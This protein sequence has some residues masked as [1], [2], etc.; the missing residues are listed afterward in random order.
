MRQQVSD[1]HYDWKGQKCSQIVTGARSPVFSNGSHNVGSCCRALRHS[2]QNGKRTASQNLKLN[3][4]W[5]NLVYS[6]C[7][8]SVFSYTG[9][10]CML[11]RLELGGGRGGSVWW[12]EGRR[13]RGKQEGTDGGGVAAQGVSPALAR[14]AGVRQQQG[15]T[16]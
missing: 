16:T 8:G 6:H 10:W 13:K 14:P 11:G 15:D 4:A 7:V 1:C 2:R 12:E 3:G 9:G 5:H